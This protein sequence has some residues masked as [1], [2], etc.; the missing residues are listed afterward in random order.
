MSEAGSDGARR[1]TLGRVAGVFGVKG[2]VKIVSNTRPAENL[3]KYPQWWLGADEGY[4]ATLV[5]AKAQVI[6]M[7]YDG[8]NRIK[9]EDYQDARGLSPDV[10]YRYDTPASVSAGE[11]TFVTSAQVKGKLSSVTDLS[12]GE[13]LSYDARG[14]TAWKV[15][16]V[17][18]PA[19]GQPFSFQSQFAYDSLDRLTTLTYPDRDT[20]GYTYNG[21]NLP[22]T[23]TGGP[24]GF[25]IAA[26]QLVEH[27]RVGLGGGFV[28]GARAVEH[29]AQLDLMQCIVQTLAAFA[30]GDSEQMLFFTQGLQH[31]Q[32]AVKQ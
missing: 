19:N 29:A 2:W 8:A 28:G 4:L 25:I 18:D 21:R 30:G 17:I 13:V 31:G 24:G 3:L 14:R 9:T 20:V 12:G 5:D 27:S 7:S 26:H 15:K 11:G 23:I 32:D 6:S 10:S 16:R 22:K 1:V